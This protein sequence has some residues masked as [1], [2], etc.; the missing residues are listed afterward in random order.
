MCTQGEVY[1]DQHVHGRQREKA[2]RGSSDTTG[3][4]GRMCVS[5]GLIFLFI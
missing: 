2:K 3:E 4:A 5:N 1:F